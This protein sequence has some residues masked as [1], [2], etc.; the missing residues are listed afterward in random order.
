MRIKVRAYPS[1][2]Q[3]RII[4]G[5]DFL[6]IYL[7]IPA[8]KGKAN[9]RLLELLSRYLNLRKSSLKIVRGQTKRDKIIDIL[10]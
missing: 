4:E 1:S 10:E 6:K 8:E 9:K 5:N 2:K 3:E 7:T